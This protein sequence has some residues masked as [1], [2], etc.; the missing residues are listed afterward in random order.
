MEDPIP[1]FSYVIKELAKR[2]TD[3][4]Y[5]HLV[6]PV[7]SGDNDAEHAHDTGSAEVRRIEL[8]INGLP[9]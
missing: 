6:E 9:N 8:G 7:V 4:A 5:I 3:L 1:T 2:H